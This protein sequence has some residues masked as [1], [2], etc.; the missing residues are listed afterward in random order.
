MSESPGKRIPAWLWGGLTVVVVVI[1][2]VLALR[3]R[4]QAPPESFELDL[5]KYQQVDPALVKYTE[6]TSIDPGLQ[7]VRALATS[8]EDRIY[9]TGEN[10]VALFDLGGAEV[11]RYQI[12][13]SPDCLAVAPDGA[14]LLG[15]RTHVEVMNTQG[16]IEA[17]WPEP[18]PKTHITSIAADVQDV[19]VA[20]A[21]NRVVLRYDRQGTLLN[22][23]GEADEAQGIPGLIIPS[24][25]FD[26]A[27]DNLGALWA[28]DTGRHGFEQYRPSGDLVTAWYRP[29]MDVDG[30]CGCCNPAHVA[31]LSDGSLVTAEK[32]VARVKV[33]SV[34]QKLDGFVAQPTAFSDSPDGSLTCDLET[35]IRDVAVDAK[36]RI[37][38]LDGR[39]NK[40]RVFERN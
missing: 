37:L 5:A 24:P 9:V 14:M 16:E 25:Y 13:G 28:V 11:A 8:P 29:S 20:D 34:D 2:T 36:G 21:G 17:V 10:A 26:V 4:P 22:R 39:R 27:F 18:G 32:G 23:I 12:E 1:A 31:F 7:H 30:F 33:F 6:A 19:Y 15:L 38:V 35:P 3:D 40:I